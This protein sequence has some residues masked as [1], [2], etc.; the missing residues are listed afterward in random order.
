M[1]DDLEIWT[2]PHEWYRF[3]N[4]SF[5]LRASS[6]V[7]ARPWAG[8][9]NVYGP[10]AQLW[11]PKFTATVTDESVWPDIAAFFE[12]LGGQAGLLRIGDASRVECRYNRE[13]KGAQQDFSDGTSF[14]DETGFIE[15]LM[16]SAA[17]LIAPAKRGDTF[18]KIGGLL[19]SVVGA[20]RR[21]DHM[22]FRPNGIANGIPR[23]H[24]VSV[25][26]N[27]NADGQCG[28]RI[29]P[30]LRA[31]LAAGD[32]I[33]LDHPTSV[34]HLIDDSQGEM[35]ITPPLLANFGFSLVEAIENI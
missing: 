30:P 35:E 34:F 15:G 4:L 9:N 13:H 28:V 33:V 27:T 22:E 10:H 12:R 1:A 31:N 7:S 19:P 18:V 21:G 14:T 11:M 5:Q 20:L 2:Y 6:L 8:G 16:P 3:T 23:L 17:Y 26:G 29:S 32:Q 24:S 25:Q